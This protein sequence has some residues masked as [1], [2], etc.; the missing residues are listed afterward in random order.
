MFS[1]HPTSRWAATSNTK[2]ACLSCL[3]RHISFHIR[4]RGATGVVNIFGGFM[5]GPI[6]SNIVREW[7][8]KWCL[9]GVGFWI[10][11]NNAPN[12]GH[13]NR[14]CNTTTCNSLLNDLQRVQK[15]LTLKKAQYSIGP[16]RV[17]QLI[18]LPPQPSYVSLLNSNLPTRI[19]EVQNLQK[20]NDTSSN[21]TEP[22]LSLSGVV[23][24]GI[25]GVWLQSISIGRFTDETCH[26]PLTATW[27]R[28]CQSRCKIF[29][30]VWE[31][32]RLPL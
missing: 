13:R 17:F 1:C 5:P 8:T 32:A 24:V 22:A 4:R 6:L 16:T 29:G 28:Q 2:T 11:S 12:W 31:T 21:A 30:D 26:R 25:V 9:W 19:L 23:C 15:S 27:L 7:L 14:N 20:K 10:K 3:Q 18:R